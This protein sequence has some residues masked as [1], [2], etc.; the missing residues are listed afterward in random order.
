MDLCIY[1]LEHRQMDTIKRQGVIDVAFY[2]LCFFLKMGKNEK[3][4]KYQCVMYE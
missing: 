4:G 1:N 2:F 3:M